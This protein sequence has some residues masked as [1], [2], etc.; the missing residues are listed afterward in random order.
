MTIS[1]L[2]DLRRIY[3]SELSLF[4]AVGEGKT[5][6]QDYFDTLSRSLCPGVPAHALF[7]GA[8]RCIQP[9]R[10]LCTNCP[11]LRSGSWCCP[12]P[13]YPIKPLTMSNPA[14]LK[15]S[16]LWEPAAL[17]PTAPSR[18]LGCRYWGATSC[19]TVSQA[20]AVSMT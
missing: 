3:M 14:C 15:K 16:G 12:L 2:G 8:G 5:A 18:R 7:T 20:S 11:R 9:H 1:V 10:C 19:R 6:T 13:R 17:P 4:D